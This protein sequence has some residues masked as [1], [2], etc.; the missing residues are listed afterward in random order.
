MEGLDARAAL[1]DDAELQSAEDLQRATYEWWQFTTTSVLQLGLTA[2]GR[3][4]R[5]A[6]LAL[7]DFANAFGERPAEGRAARNDEGLRT[8]A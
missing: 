4:Q 3:E 8:P 1:D 5:L 7:A 2:Q 6:L